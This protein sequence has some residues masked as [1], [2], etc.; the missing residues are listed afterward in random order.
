MNVAAIGKTVWGGVQQIP[1]VV[2]W[3]ILGIVF[4]KW[5]EFSSVQRGRRE[6]GAER[7]K[8]A[9]EVE[10][11]VV[12]NIEEHTREVIAE[13]DAVREHTAAS[14]LPDGTATLPDNHYRD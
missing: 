12:N 4:F 1:A 9:L 3:I 2:W 11:D 10:R 6:E 14:V 5:V 7:D 13:A 8:E